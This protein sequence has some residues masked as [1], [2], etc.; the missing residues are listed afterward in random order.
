MSNS[1]FGYQ[2]VSVDRDYSIGLTPRFF[3]TRPSALSSHIEESQFEEVIQNVNKFFIEAEKISWRTVIEETCS[4]LTCGLTECCMKN[5][6]ERKM[7]ELQMYLNELNKEYQDL[8][9]I[10]PI[11]NGFLCFEISIFTVGQEN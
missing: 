3:S 10:H 7:L 8:Q 4:C 9:F 5:Q 2:L 6:Y 11:N 1:N